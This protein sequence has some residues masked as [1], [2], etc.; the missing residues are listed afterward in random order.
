MLLAHTRFDIAELGLIVEA[1]LA[2]RGDSRGNREHP[3]SGIIV[4][5]VQAHHVAESLVLRRRRRDQPRESAD[6]L[7]QVLMCLV[8]Q[9]GAQ[10]KERDRSA[11]VPKLL[12]AAFAVAIVTVASNEHGQLQRGFI[13]WLEHRDIEH[14]L[15][16]IS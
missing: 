10:R 12:P 16:I 8:E 1:T 7:I 15:P 13:I 3:P 9:Q 2:V 6:G 4:K 14:L 5:R 11:P